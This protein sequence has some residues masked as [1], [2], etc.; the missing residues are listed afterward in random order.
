MVLL[1]TSTG[2]SAADATVQNE[3]ARRTAL[4]MLPEP[5]IPNWHCQG[6]SR[7]GIQQLRLAAQN[8]RF[9]KPFAKL[10]LAMMITK[11]SY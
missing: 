9:L 11:L 4:Q 6:R 7:A 8:G 1:S 3:T 5:F 2:L 10:L